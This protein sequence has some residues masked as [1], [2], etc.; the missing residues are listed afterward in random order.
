MGRPAVRIAVFATAVLA[1][2]G[3]VRIKVTAVQARY[4]R[5]RRRDRHCNPAVLQAHLI[6]QIGQGAFRGGQGRFLSFQKE[7]TT[8]GDDEQDAQDES[9]VNLH[10]HLLFCGR[11]IFPIPAF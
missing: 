1:R 3:P 4:F 8:A 11:S 10:S 5:Q 6:D 7:A 9:A 2:V